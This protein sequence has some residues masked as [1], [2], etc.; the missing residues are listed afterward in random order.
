MNVFSSKPQLISNTAVS[1]NLS[2]LRAIIFLL[3]VLLVICLLWF[4]HYQNALSI[5]G[6]IRVQKN[7]FYF[8]NSFLGKYPNLLFNLTQLGDA[9]VFLS[10][11]SVFIV[12]T[13]KIWE[14]LIPA[15]LLSFI[16]SYSLKAIFAVP[17]PAAVF[18]HNSF[19][20]VGKI[21]AGN[22]S[23]PSG[24]SI[25]VFT[26]LAVL[27]F[28][29]M[30][31]KMDNKIIWSLLIV[32]FGI[33][34]IF[35]RVGIGAHYPIDVIAGGIVGYIAGLTG[36]FISCRYKIWSRITRKKYYPIFILFLLICA[37][38]L[39][40]KIIKQNLIIYYLSLASLIVPLY[41]IIYAYAKS[42]KK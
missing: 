2:R 42:I 35:T 6:Y 31:R 4:L 39:I 33:M 23:L 16:L 15:L 40:N 28:A 20:I 10:F 19:V 9:I 3:P 5:D 22:T 26:I 41:K 13:P 24:H 29:F 8:L 37:A 27:L 12:Y 38:T 25:T 30:P 21:R 32:S 36:I 14:V 7:S 1:E 11:L 18:D 34:L 17:R